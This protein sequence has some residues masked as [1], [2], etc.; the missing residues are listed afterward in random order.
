MKTYNYLRGI[1]VHDFVRHNERLK[2]IANRTLDYDN[3]FNVPPEF[4]DFANFY[5]CHL[6][7]TCQI[8]WEKF[9]ELPPRITKNHPIDEMFVLDVLFPD[10]S[11]GRMKEVLEKR[12]AA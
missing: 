7:R 1:I 6:T 9:S 3:P 8:R 11:L 12:D 4:Y 5:L 2:H 10:V